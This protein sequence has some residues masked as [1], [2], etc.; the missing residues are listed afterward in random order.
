M[1]K[2]IWV[3]PLLFARSCDGGGGCDEEEMPETEVMEEP[4]S[5]PQPPDPDCGF[6]EA[7]SEQACESTDR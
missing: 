7:Q 6:P 2:M 1:F 3:I 5:T 4:E